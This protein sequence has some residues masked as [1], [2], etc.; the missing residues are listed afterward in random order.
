MAPK[1]GVVFSEVTSSM[2]STSTWT[3]YGQSKLANIYFTTQ[4]AKLYPKIK[5]VSVHPG[6]VSTNLATSGPSQTYTLF[7]PIF[8]ILNRYFFTSVEKG[9]F[10]QL[11]AATGKRE[12]IKQ[13]AF[14][15]PVGIEHKAKLLATDTEFAGQLWRFTEREL[16]D[17]GY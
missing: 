8:Y 10:N 2:E 17:H 1:E 4:M 16:Q 15:Y 14:Y 6:V 7:K 12:D 3:R 9:A 5:S 11:W 13:G